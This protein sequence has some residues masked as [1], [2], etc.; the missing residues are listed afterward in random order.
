MK[1]IKPTEEIHITLDGIPTARD[2]NEKD[3]GIYFTWTSK[4]GEHKEKVSSSTITWKDK[5]GAYNA[6]I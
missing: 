4:D 2:G 6:T 1:D 3:S 5:E